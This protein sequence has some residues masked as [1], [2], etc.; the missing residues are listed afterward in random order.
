ML[1]LE[2]LVSDLEVLKL[3]YMTL[4]LHRDEFQTESEALREIFKEAKQQRN[5]YRTVNEF[6]EDMERR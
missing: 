2:L 6:E 1:I 3:N 5:Q 4:W